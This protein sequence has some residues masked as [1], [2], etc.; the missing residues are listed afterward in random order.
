MR[1]PK[2]KQDKDQFVSELFDWLELHGSTRYDEAVSQLAHALQTANLAVSEASDEFQITAALLHDIGHLIIGEH[3]MD[4]AFLKKDANHELAGSNWLAQQFG[5][6]VSE[7][8]RLHVK[9]KRWLYTNDVSYREKLS[10]ASKRS[11]ELQ[12]GKLSAKDC[13]ELEQEPYFEQAVAL[14][15]WDDRAK[16][17]GK[18]VPGTSAY[19]ETVRNTL[20]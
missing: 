15:L 6:S 2:Y 9:A 19:R 14:R 4:P 11:L 10:L 8:V 12:G 18:D 17:S 13:E 1:L 5:V 20:C 7:P 16:V 3:N